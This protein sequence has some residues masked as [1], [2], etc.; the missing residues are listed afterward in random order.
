MNEQ[1]QAIDTTP[2]P[3]N[4][5]IPFVN[6]RKALAGKRLLESP[7]CSLATALVEA[8]GYSPSTAKAA[9]RNNLSAKQC[10]E[11]ARK[12]YGDT[13]LTT[14]KVHALALA[15]LRLS[16]S[17]S[18]PDE[19]RRTSLGALGRLIEVIYKW[20]GGSKPHPNVDAASFVDRVEWLAGVVAEIRS[21]EATMIDAKVIEPS[22]TAESSGE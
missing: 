20:E 14:L 5:R 10:I 18:N 1:S 15:K 6:V 3:N 2:K 21:R 17:A 22:S 9:Q 12:V 7:G 8:G 19:L 13:D 4:K 11:E 16:Q